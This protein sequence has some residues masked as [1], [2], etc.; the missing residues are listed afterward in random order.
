MNLTGQAAH[1]LA[2]AAVRAGMCLTIVS[3]A[4]AAREERNA[5][6]RLP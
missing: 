1:P 3:Q 4:L 2:R 5:G 6:L